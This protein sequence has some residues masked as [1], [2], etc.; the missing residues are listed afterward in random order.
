MAT[1]LKYL[2]ATFA[3]TY[4]LGEK[5]MNSFKKGALLGISLVVIPVFLMGATELSAQKGNRF[6]L[7]I[8]NQHAGTPARA[9]IIDTE[10]GESWFWK[11]KKKLSRY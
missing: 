7:H 1:D 9:F 4:L 2:T 5:T 8:S 3:I 6:E 11:T 10:T